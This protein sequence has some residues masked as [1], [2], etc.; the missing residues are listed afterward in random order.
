M[1]TLFSRRFKDACR[2]C[3]KPLHGIFHAHN[4]LTAKHIRG[5]DVLA[6]RFVKDRKFTTAAR[7]FLVDAFTNTAELETMNYHDSGTGNTAEANSQ[8]ALITPTGIA[9]V[10][11]TQSQPTADVYRTVAQ[12]T[13]DNTYAIVEH[14]VFSASTVGTLLDRTLFTAVN[15][16]LND[17]IEFT[18][19]L[20]IVAEA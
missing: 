18:F 1:L 15:V 10:A 6:Q 14:G 3:H 17:K 20:T 19:N 12:I 5:G 8:T 7:D 9:R 4:D 11:G 16:V 2:V 13:Y